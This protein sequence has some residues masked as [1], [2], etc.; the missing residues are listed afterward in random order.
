[1]W[2]FW[3]EE[4]CPLCFS[5]ETW[6]TEITLWRSRLARRIQKWISQRTCMGGCE[7]HK[8]GWWQGQVVGCFEHGDECSGS[9]MCLGI[10]LTISF[11]RVASLH[12]LS[13]IICFGQPQ[14][15]SGGDV[16]NVLLTSAFQHKYLKPWKSCLVSFGGCHPTTMV[17][18]LPAVQGV[19]F[20]LSPKSN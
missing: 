10:F 4:K 19:E 14:L 18:G 6:R 20:V 1:M 17:P 13:F 12:W 11:S 3:E 5:R 9:I 16:N 7:L 15:L 8:Y 2:L